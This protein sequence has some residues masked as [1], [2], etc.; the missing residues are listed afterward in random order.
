MN[1]IQAWAARSPG[2]VLEPY[3][4][5]PGPLEPEQVEVA[6]EFCGICY[7]DLAVLNNEWSRSVFPVVPGHE[8]VGRVTAVGSQVRT[9]RPGQRVGVGW[10]AHS[11]SHCAACMR[12]DHNFCR[13]RKPTIVGRHGGFA[14]RLRVH[15]TWAVSLPEGLDPASSAPLM[16]GGLTVFSPLLLNDVKPTARVGVV[17]LGGLGHMALRFARA[18]GCEVTAL[19]SNASKLEE[20][21]QLGAHRVLL[22]THP[23]ELSSIAGEIDFLLVTARAPLDWPRLVEALAPDGRIHLVGVPNEIIP[24]DVRPHLIM[25][26]RGVQGSSTG[27]PSLLATLLAFAARH[28]ISAQ[29]ELFPMRRVNDAIS[30]LRSGKARYRVVLQADFS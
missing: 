1:E 13:E 16:C 14:D 4:Y 23:D 8:V 30:H 17:G 9:V 6:V 25:W 3:C 20:A 22:H 29:V 11:C 10:W 24:I 19:T 21:R 12:G 27:S 15:W 26:R 18:W 5:E 7:S 28:S 2:D